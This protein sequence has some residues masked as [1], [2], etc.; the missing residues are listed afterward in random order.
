MATCML[1]FGEGT[2]MVGY[3]SREKWVCP[4][5]SGTGNVDDDV[6]QS[7]RFPVCEKCGSEKKWIYVP[8]VMRCPN[9]EKE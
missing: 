4:N 8:G 7:K 3:K 1:C 6:E 2:K 9:C 5:C